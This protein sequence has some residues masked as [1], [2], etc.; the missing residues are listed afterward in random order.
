MLPYA[1]DSDEAMI[2]LIQISYTT[3][4]LTHNHGTEFDPEFKGYHNGNSDPRGFGHVGFIVDDV[5]TFCDDLDKEG[6]RF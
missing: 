2:N 6:V 3:V 4:E 5:V 1:P